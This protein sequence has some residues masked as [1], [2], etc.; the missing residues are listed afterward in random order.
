MADKRGPII[1]EHIYPPIPVRT[2]DWSAYRDPEG[3]NGLGPTEDAAILDLLETEAMFDDGDD[4]YECDC[5]AR[6]AEPHS[7]L[8]CRDCNHGGIN[9]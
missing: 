1:T 2:C 6:Y 8:V 9:G 4:P 5:G 7:V 3:R